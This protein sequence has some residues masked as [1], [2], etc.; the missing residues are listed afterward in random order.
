MNAELGVDASLAG[1]QGDAVALSPDGSKIAFVAKT[2]ARGPAQLYVRQLNEL[3]ATTL[4][5]TDDASSPFFSPDGQW[6]AFFAAGALKKISV[7][8][9]AAVTLC[10]APNGRGGAWGEDGTILFAPDSQPGVYFQRV[11]S[12]GGEPTPLLQTVQPEHWQRW[13][14]L[15][16]G[17][18]AVLYTGDGSPGD[19]ND[20]NIVI[21]AFPSGPR[22]VVQRGAYHGRYLPSHHLV[23]IQRRNAVCRP[24]RSRSDR[25]Q[26]QTGGRRSRHQLEFG[27]R[28]RPV[29]AVVQRHAGLPS[30]VQRGGEVAISWL[31]R[32]GKTTPMMPTST[33]WFNLAFAPDGNRLAL[34]ISDQGQNDLWIYEWARQAMTR[35]TF[36]DAHDSEPVWTP[37]SR[38]IAFSSGR[39]V[40]AQ[41]LYW[42][43]ADGTGNAQRLTESQNLQL[44][45]SWHPNGRIL[46]FEEQTSP[47]NWDVWVL[48][49][50]GD[51]A[52][53][54]TPGTPTALLSDAASRAK[55]SVL[56]GREVARV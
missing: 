14:Q 1:G 16:P 27:D 4:R 25:N 54:W 45:R 7:S 21:Q 44:P 3:E 6:V 20:A 46:A 10:R 33:N 47:T 42:R 40:V 15:L 56:S 18:K 26:G 48:P 35:L 24:I 31:D 29:R 49:L 38:R 30:R 37:D 11:S 13:P 41:N 50:T 36:E 28:R 9:G 55:T 2:S 22:T 12:A 39:E 5:G 17:G 23:Y 8:G 32:A 53:G 43:R 52:S 19:A 34:Q 51:D